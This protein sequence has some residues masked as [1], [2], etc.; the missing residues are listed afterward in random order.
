MLKIELDLIKKIDIDTTNRFDINASY[1]K[2]L[3]EY[4]KIFKKPVPCNIKKRIKQTKIIWIKDEF[5]AFRVLAEEYLK[6]GYTC[7]K[8]G[9][10]EGFIPTRYKK[11]EKLFK[12]QKLV[13]SE[14]PR[15]LSC[16]DCSF[17]FSPL[18]VSVYRNLKLDLRIW[19]FYTFISDDGSI[20]YPIKSISEILKVSYSTAKR[21]KD[22]TENK[23]NRRFTDMEAKKYIKNKNE[24]HP[25]VKIILDRAKILLE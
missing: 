19:L 8:C 1:N 20:N 14:R 23:V 3:S 21:I 13:R 17:T 12:T 18:S 15:T 25:M 5:V 16:L 6:A 9:S 10:Q 11:I 4:Y 2:W 7:P 22:F 24:N